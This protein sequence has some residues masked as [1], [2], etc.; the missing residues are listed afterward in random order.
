MFTQVKLHNKVVVATFMNLTHVV[1]IT[2]WCLCL[3]SYLY[4]QLPASASNLKGQFYKQNV[5]KIIN[6]VFITVYYKR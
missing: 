4:N 2:D 6:L 5:A 3:H 1:L